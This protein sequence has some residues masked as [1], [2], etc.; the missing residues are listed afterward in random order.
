MEILS[1]SQA[2]LKNDEN[3]G[4]FTPFNGAVLEIKAC[5]AWFN[6][7]NENTNQRRVIGSREE[8]TRKKSV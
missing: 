2:L 3:E 7:K 4:W 6:R 1:Y 5:N 8:R